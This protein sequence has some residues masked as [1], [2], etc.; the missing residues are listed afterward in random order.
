MK[1]CP[2]SRSKLSELCDNLIHSDC[3]VSGRGKH[4]M[5]PLHLAILV[6]EIGRERREMQEKEGEEF[7]HS[8][9][10]VVAIELNA[11]NGCLLYTHTHT[12]K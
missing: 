12:E 8:C 1:Q 7:V 9:L 11:H 3:D 4:N 10:V 6:S 5:T 2:L